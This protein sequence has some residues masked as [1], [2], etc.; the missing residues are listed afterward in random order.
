MPSGFGR[1]F[2]GRA[3]VALLRVFF[4]HP[5]R[6]FYQREL[7][8][9][10]QDRLFVVQLALRRLVST[11]VVESL[12]RGNRTFFRARAS[13]PAFADL[14]SMILKTFGLGDRLRDALAP[15]VPRMSV[16]FVYGS[17]ARHE[18]QDSSDVDLMLIGQLRGR[19]VASALAP[20]KRELDREINVTVYR[21]EE[22]RKRYRQRHP[23]IREVIE[24]PKIFLIGDD[25]EIR[26]LLTRR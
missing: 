4:L 5:D 3:L 24:G 8:L 16:A 20:A 21:P 10:T 2:A 17:V 25:D 7:V 15:L 6:E 13:H 1:L 19:E 22:V 12:R 26:R 18:E 23:F 14:K 9:L 11:G